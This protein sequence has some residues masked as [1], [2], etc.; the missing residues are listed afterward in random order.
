MESCWV[1]AEGESSLNEGPCGQVQQRRV[2]GGASVCKHV[3][4]GESVLDA[5]NERNVIWV[6]DL[7]CVLQWSLPSVVKSFVRQVLKENPNIKGST[8]LV[9]AAQTYVSPMDGVHAR[10]SGMPGAVV[11]PGS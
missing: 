1:V 10:K 7:F 6:G 4:G 9:A 2:A 5:T 8:E 3:L 11:L